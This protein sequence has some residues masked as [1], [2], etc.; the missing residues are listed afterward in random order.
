[1]CTGTQCLGTMH[2]PLRY[3]FCGVWCERRQKKNDTT[4]TKSALP[5]WKRRVKKPRNKTQVSTAH[6]RAQTYESARTRRRR[7]RVCVRKS[8]T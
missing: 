3:L 4:K 5:A 7:R 6:L 1:M 8:L 2:I